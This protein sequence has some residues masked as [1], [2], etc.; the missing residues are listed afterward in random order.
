MKKNRFTTEQ[1]IAVLKEAET[2]NI[3]IC[4]VW[5]VHFQLIHIFFLRA[6]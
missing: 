1:I 6:Y 3:L 5:R 2:G 4:Q